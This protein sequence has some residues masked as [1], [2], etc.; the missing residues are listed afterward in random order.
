MLSKTK[1]IAITYVG[2][3]REMH[4]TVGGKRYDFY[5]DNRYTRAIREDHASQL[6]G[7]GNFMPAESDA[8]KQAQARANKLRAKA[9]PAAKNDGGKDPTTGEKKPTE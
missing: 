2:R 9:K 6:L 7:T 4:T 5:P 8:A 1:K 3:H